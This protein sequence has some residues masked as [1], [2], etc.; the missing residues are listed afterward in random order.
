MSPVVNILVKNPYFFPTPQILKPLFPCFYF[1]KICSHHHCHHFHLS[2][3]WVLSIGWGRWFFV[4][5][6]EKEELSIFDVEYGEEFLREA[7]WFLSCKIF[8]GSKLI[9][10]LFL[11]KQGSSLFLPPRGGGTLGQNIYRWMSRG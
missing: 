11:K 1:R 2:F 5:N 4:K 6:L 9:S 10:T 7:L 3:C 8:L